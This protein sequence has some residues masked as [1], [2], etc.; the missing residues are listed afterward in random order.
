LKVKHFINWHYK[1]IL[2]TI[3]ILLV[4]IINKQHTDKINSNLD[5]AEGLLVGTT[6]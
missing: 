1:N 3:F 6:S 5:K 2:K 4:I